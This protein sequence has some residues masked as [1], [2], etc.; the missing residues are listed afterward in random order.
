[1]GSIPTGPTHIVVSDPGRGRTGR[2]APAMAAPPGS[3]RSARCPRRV[4]STSRL[5]GGMLTTGKHH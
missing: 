5:G 3:C 2:P 4:P 1:V